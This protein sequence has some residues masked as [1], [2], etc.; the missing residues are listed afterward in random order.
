M[1]VIMISSPTSLRRVVYQYTARVTVYEHYQ[2]G[3]MP[4]YP[5]NPRPELDGTNE[6]DPDRLNYYQGLIGVLRWICELG[7]LD[8]RPT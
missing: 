7:R 6:L 5:S 4:T 2:P 3:S 8:L 1:T